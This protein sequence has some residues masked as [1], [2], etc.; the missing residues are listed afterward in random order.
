M[1]WFC[2][3]RS[4]NMMVNLSNADVLPLESGPAPLVKQRLIHPYCF[5]IITVN[6][7][8]SV[9]PFPPLNEAALPE[10]VNPYTV[11]V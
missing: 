1:V 5:K 8:W 3:R 10:T 6:S 9:V 7:P 2:H 11:M 4:L